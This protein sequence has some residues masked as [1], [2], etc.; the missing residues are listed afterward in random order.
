M[1]TS[2]ACLLTFVGV[3]RLPTCGF[4]LAAKQVEGRAAQMACRCGTTTVPDFPFFY[5]F[6]VFFFALSLSLVPAS[7]PF[8]VL[9]ARLLSLS[10]S[11]YLFSAPL[12]SFSFFSASLFFFSLFSVS[13]ALTCGI[14]LA[15]RA[16]SDIRS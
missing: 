4:E 9:S 11:V 15:R 7:F 5:F 8:F 10:L 14:L 12:L 1:D 3:V 13:F 16:R 6:F 2:W